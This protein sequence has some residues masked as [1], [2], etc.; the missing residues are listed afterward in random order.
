MSLLLGVA[1]EANER[2]LDVST[3]FY[4]SS[5]SILFILV[6]SHDRNE[7]LLST[8]RVA[9]FGSYISF[10]WSIRVRYFMWLQ[11]LLLEYT[12]AKQHFCFFSCVTPSLRTPSPK[13]SR[14]N[15]SKLSKMLCWHRIRRTSELRS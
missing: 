5:S 3:L 12:R 11:I 6:M 8:E 15:N 2:R 4:F 7:I 13:N 9:D 10:P 1:L 14:S